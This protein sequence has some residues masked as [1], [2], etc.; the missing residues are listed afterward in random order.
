MI[1]WHE[2]VTHIKQMR[3]TQV[4]II[5]FGKPEGKDSLLGTARPRRE[6]NIKLHFKGTGYWQGQ[7]HHSGSVTH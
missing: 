5:L 7:L 6:N 2:H 3:D 4:Y 1:K